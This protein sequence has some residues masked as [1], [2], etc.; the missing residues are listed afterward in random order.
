MFSE[1]LSNVF[2][3]LFLFTHRAADGISYYGLQ[4]NVSNVGGNEFLN[5]FLAAVVEVPGCIT[6]WFLMDRLGRRWVTVGFFLMIGVACML[7]AVGKNLL[8]Y[9]ESFLS[10]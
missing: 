3:L 2:M 4:I 10:C 5:F 9:L 8:F 1:F 7:P 6:S